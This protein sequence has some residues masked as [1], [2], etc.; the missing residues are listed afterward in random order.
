MS[1]EQAI[2]ATMEDLSRRIDA[3][4]EGQRPEEILNLVEVMIVIGVHLLKESTRKEYVRG[5][6]K[7][8]L[9]QLEPIRPSG[10]WL[11]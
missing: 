9:E 3:L 6:L 10:E 7:G 1:V 5:F 11:H 4:E 8:A 2:A